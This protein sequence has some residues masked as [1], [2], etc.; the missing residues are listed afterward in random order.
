MGGGG[1]GLKDNFGQ[2]YALMQKSFSF[3]TLIRFI[4]DTELTN[5]SS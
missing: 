3:M 1:G 5:F 4:L 2:R